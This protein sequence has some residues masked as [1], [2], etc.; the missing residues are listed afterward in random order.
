MVGA[1][2][3][4]GIVQASALEQSP[5]WGMWWENTGNS[6]TDSLGLRWGFH[7]SLLD[8][9]FLFSKIS[10]TPDQPFDLADLH[11]DLRS[12]VFE[13]GNLAPPEFWECLST[14]AT[15]FQ[16]IQAED[17]DYGRK[18]HWYQGMLPLR[19]SA[20]SRSDPAR[21]LGAGIGIPQ[22][23][24]AIF[25]RSLSGDF[26]G[27]DHFGCMGQIIVENQVG[28]SWRFD[29]SGAWYHSWFQSL[30][31]DGSW[32]PV[33]DGS[34]LLLHQSDDWWLSSE[35]L[36]PTVIDHGQMVLRWATDW[37]RLALLAQE[38]V[39]QR[40]DSAFNL[41]LVA[42][43]IIRDTKGRR[44]GQL[45]CTGI[46]TDSEYRD[47]HGVKPDY[48][49]YLKLKAIVQPRSG[50]MV[51]A[52]GSAAV[53]RIPELADQSALYQ[54]ST[55]A[56]AGGL[57]YTGAILQTAIALENTRNREKSGVITND[58]T[59]SAKVGVSFG[60]QDNVRLTVNT[61]LGLNEWQADQWSLDPKLV[62]DYELSPVQFHMD[63]HGGITAS[64]SGSQALSLRMGT[65]I[66]ARW[67]C[68]HIGQFEIRLTLGLPDATTMATVNTWAADQ[69]LA[70]LKRRL[71]IS[72]N[73]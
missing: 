59:V 71:E 6:A 11:F 30:S 56:W 67:N 24:S 54:A 38:S 58:E 61:S 25:F 72:L 55:V 5:R 8:A 51:W 23:F 9:N 27:W 3:G 69:C 7:T 66:G 19:F 33:N 21:T 31:G 57:E 29:L 20:L 40:L 2:M 4:L 63:L 32:L 22:W 35:L 65:E 39:P 45:D 1:A 64:L 34:E 62:V 17:P 53:A 52:Q 15:S 48:Q 47:A 12:P 18:D 43:G 60:L 13:A 37:L 50:L 49:N 36:R 42:T 73:Y 46:Y 44:L 26:S 28:P 70:N 14:N 68:P 16:S 41:G 10:F